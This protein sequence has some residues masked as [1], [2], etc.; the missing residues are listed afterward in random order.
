MYLVDLS[1]FNIYQGGVG[2]FSVWWDAFDLS[3]YWCLAYAGN[4]LAEKRRT[5]L[6]RAFDFFV[7]SS[8]LELYREEVHDLYGKQQASRTPLQ[9]WVRICPTHERTTRLQE[10]PSWI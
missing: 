10:G 5:P 3:P 1:S 4:L 6:A 8:F 9:V 2:S 7:E